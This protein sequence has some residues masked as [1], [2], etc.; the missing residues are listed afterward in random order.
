MTDINKTV[1]ILGAGC[2]AGKLPNGAGFPLACEFLSALD[3]FAQR[4]T[5][6]DCRKLKTLVDETS[7]LLRKENVQ[8]LDALAA[9]L[10]A[11]AHGSL[12]SSLTI[13]EKQ[14]LHRQVCNARI[15]T[16]ALF[17]D[18]ERKN[19]KI[20]LSRYDNFLTELFGNSTDWAKASRNS[21]A[22]VLTFNYDRLFEMA[23]I[24]R[25][26][27]DTGQNNLY[28]KSLLNSGLDY[29][30]GNGFEIAHDR[31]SFLKLHGSVGIRARN[32]AGDRTPCIY[33]YY[34]GLPGEVDKP[35][36][37]ELFFAHSQNINPFERDPEPLIVFPHEKPFVS[38]GT[39][40]LL[41]F[42]NYIPSV[43]SEAH[44]MITK[45]TT[46]WSIGYSFAPMD[47]A[48]VLA[49]FRSAT[50]CKKLV[51]QDMPGV[52]ESTAQRIQMKWVTPEGLK[53][54]VEPYSQP[55]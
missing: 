8:T 22:S 36:N 52:A 7:G 31:F 53:F 21:N 17:M 18:L 39:N 10:G 48:D 2:S 20:G 49:L 41:S 28:G 40:T 5:G 14:L 55:F 11:E 42:R 6:D 16:A 51:V 32:E 15:A 12:S 34:D 1:Y 13:R 26:K 37:D 38:P 46:I 29:P 25:F 27:C 19:K 24:N 43:W 33:T 9:R 54:T 47:R 45:A 23:F 35:L 3:E 44:Q 50:N 30:Q 4:L